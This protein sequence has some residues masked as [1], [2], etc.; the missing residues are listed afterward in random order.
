MARRR[1]R[2]HRHRG[3]TG[4][5]QTQVLTAS[6]QS[7]EIAKG[8]QIL[9]GEMQWNHILHQLRHNVSISYSDVWCN[10]RHSI[11]HNFQQIW[12]L[13]H[14]V[15]NYQDLQSKIQRCWDSFHQQ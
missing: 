3:I 7:P 8:D 13:F 5:S 14:S 2:L 6:H 10:L 12:W 9:K 4:E 15:R 1:Y 11:T